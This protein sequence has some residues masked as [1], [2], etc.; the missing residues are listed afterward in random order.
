MKCLFGD[1]SL[2]N[3]FAV[4]CKD[5]A[6]KKLSLIDFLLV[7]PDASPNPNEKLD[8]NSEFCCVLKTRLAG[9]SLLYGAEVDAIRKECGPPFSNLE[10]FVELKTTRHIENERHN[11]TF[12]K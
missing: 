5:I 6:F 12:K 3:I 10:S 7:S 8:T 2:S 4:V 11:T 9:H 1:S